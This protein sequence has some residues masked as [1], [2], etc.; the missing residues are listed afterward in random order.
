[1]AVEVATE[2]INDVKKR[3][4]ALRPAAFPSGLVCD[5]Q[6]KAK[7]SA[8]ETCGTKKNETPSTSTST[9]VLGGLG[10]ND[11]FS[12][13]PLDFSGK[14]CDLKR[15]NEVRLVSIIN[16]RTINSCPMSSSISRAVMRVNL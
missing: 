1:M 10:D 2:V 16:R 6:S 5:W 14:K 8:S 9:I 7:A 12:E 3:K 13:Q 4:A 11:A 15:S